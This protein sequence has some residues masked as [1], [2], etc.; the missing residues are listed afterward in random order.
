MVSSRLGLFRHF[1]T[2]RDPRRVNCCQHRLLDIVAIAICAVVA[3]AARLVDSSE[4]DDVEYAGLVELIGE[5]GLI[6]LIVLVGYYEL[7]ARLL[8]V[9]RVPT[10]TD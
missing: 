2:L 9:L 10:S 4:L 8:S 3:G 7:L 5:D 6:E 1:R